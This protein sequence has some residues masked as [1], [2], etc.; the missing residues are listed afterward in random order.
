[1]IAHHLG[2]QTGDGQPPALSQG[3]RAE[4]IGN[5]INDLLDGKK[6]IRIKNPNSEHPLAIDGVEDDEDDDE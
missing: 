2:Y 1:M 4:L 5:L 6:S 3:W